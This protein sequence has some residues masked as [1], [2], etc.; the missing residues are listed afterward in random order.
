MNNWFDREGGLA[1]T[2]IY[3]AKL[4]LFLAVPGVHLIVSGKKMLGYT[5][6]VLMALAVIIGAM[7]SLNS[8]HQSFWAILVL[9]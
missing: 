1:R 2:V 7:T 4:A 6:F 3:L 8:S 5:V 9:A